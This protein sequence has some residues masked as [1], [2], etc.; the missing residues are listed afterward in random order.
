MFDL[1][2]GGTYKLTDIKGTY[3][4]FRIFLL[5]K[6]KICVIL[7][8]FL[9]LFYMFYDKG[10]LTKSNLDK[11]IF[12]RDLSGEMAVNWPMAGLISNVNLRLRQSFT[13]Q[14]FFQGKSSIY[15]ETGDFRSTSI[16]RDLLSGVSNVCFVS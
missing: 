4:C 7:S 13:A 2:S 1:V 12:E 10:E 15:F 11:R 14:F 6:S 3:Q 8:Y 5:L 9:L 16:L